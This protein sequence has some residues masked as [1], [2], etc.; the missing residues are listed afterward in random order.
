MT[1]IVQLLPILLGVVL[2]AL[3]LRLFLRSQLSSRHKIVWTA[4]LLVVGLGIGLLLGIPS[5]RGKF[6]FLLVAIPVLAAADLL[7]LKPARTFSFWLRACG[8]E[9]C[10]V[11][12]MAGFTRLLLNAAGVSPLLAR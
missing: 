1:V 12:G 3:G 7:F 8:Y 2:W 5:I 4:F 10:T 6:L 9:V 11:F